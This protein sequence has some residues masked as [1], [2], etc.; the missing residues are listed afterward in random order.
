MHIWKANVCQNCIKMIPKW[1][2]MAPKRVPIRRPKNTIYFV[3]DFNMIFCLKGNFGNLPGPPSKPMTVQKR[4][5]NF[6][7]VTFWHPGTT[8]GRQN[9][10]IGKSLRNGNKNT[11]IWKKNQPSRG[12]KSV[13]YTRSCHKKTPFA[14][15]RQSIKSEVILVPFWHPKSTPN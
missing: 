1:H 9:V 5:K 15:L 10:D 8:H 2:K 4:Y 14:W 6:N 3:S 13:V 7:T 11:K 12:S